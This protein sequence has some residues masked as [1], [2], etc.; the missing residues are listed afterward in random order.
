M[1]PDGT[2]DAASCF[3]GGVPFD[4][5]AYHN[6]PPSPAMTTRTAGKTHAGRL[7]GAASTL[8]G[9]GAGFAGRTSV[10]SSRETG[11]GAAAP[12]KAPSNSATIG[13]NPS[14]RSIGFFAVHRATKSMMAF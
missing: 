5:N 2:I 6:P 4:S 8:A 14:G 12:D 10:S 7:D 3:T 9:A 11:A 13:A 1:S